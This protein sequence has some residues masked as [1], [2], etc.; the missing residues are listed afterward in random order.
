VQVLTEGLVEMP[1]AQWRELAT[2][3]PEF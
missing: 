3:L 2:L 1:R